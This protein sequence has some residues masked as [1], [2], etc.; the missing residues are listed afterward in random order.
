[1]DTVRVFVELHNPFPRAVPQGVYQPDGFPV[2]LR[3]GAGAGYSPYRMLLGVKSPVPDRPN[4][5]AILPGFHND[6][7]LGNPDA[8][9]ARQPTGLLPPALRPDAPPQPAGPGEA[10]YDALPSPYLRAPGPET[11]SPPQGS[12]LVGPPAEAPAP[13]PDHDAFRDPNNGAIPAA[14]PVV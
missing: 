5:A 7:V 9:A 6:N 8:A 2:P 10:G 11:N 12:L 1:T 14:T 4:G 13:F 3:L